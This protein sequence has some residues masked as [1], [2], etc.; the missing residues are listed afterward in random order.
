[1]QNRLPRKSEA[2]CLCDVFFGL[3]DVFLSVADYD[4][5][6]VIAY[7]YAEEVVCNAVPFDR[8]YCYAFD[9]GRRFVMGND[10]CHVDCL[11]V[12][13]LVGVDFF[14]AKFK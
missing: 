1:M 13:V 2:G 14:A 12:G 4:A 3:L 11:G 10:V 8:L 6:I 5:F 9:A 7:G